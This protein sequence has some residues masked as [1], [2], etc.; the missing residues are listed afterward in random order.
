[1][2]LP[3]EAD[4]TGGDYF[5]KTCKRSETECRP[6]RAQRPWIIFASANG[7]DGNIQL[8]PLN[9]KE[10]NAG[11][12]ERALPFK[13]KLTKVLQTFVSLCVSNAAGL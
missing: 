1:M 8:L 10:I 11:S 5:H 3:C 2:H 9:Y 13:G 4:K 12:L 7:I 6:F